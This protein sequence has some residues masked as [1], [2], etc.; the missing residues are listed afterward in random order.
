MTTLTINHNVEPQWRAHIWKWAV[1]V[2]HRCS[3]TA[4]AAMLVVASPLAQCQELL[5]STAASLTN[6]FKDIGAEFEKTHPGTKVNFNFAASDILLKQIVEGAPA[7]V[8]ASA[9]Q[10]AMDSAAQQNAIVRAT[11]S[12]FA[13][14]RLVLAIPVDSKLTLTSLEDLKQPGMKSIA[15]SQPATVPVGRYARG[16][17]DQAKLWTALEDK[18]IYTQN[19]RQSLDYAARGEVDAAFV[20]AT[21]VAIQKDK[22]KAALEIPTPT[23]VTYPIALVKSSKQSKLAADFVTLVKSE[24]G[25]K[26]LQGYGFAMP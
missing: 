21:D 9:D 11:R 3:I 25:Q 17:L 10:K 19:V 15:I 2:T 14:N 12:N 13:A 20:Y 8:F 26:I 1:H 23:P 6:A 7:D 16:A 18:F 5:I 22:V 24:T 4:I